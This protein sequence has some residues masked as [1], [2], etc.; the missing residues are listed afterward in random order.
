LNWRR[1][2]YQSAATLLWCLHKL[3]HHLIIYH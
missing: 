2:V 3:Y 1:G